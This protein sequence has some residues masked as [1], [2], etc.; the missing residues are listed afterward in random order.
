M[1]HDEK[2]VA[3]AENKQFNTVHF[4][5]LWTDVINNRDQRS[6]ESEPRT[7]KK[8]KKREKL[9]EAK[10]ANQPSLMQNR[11]NGTRNYRRSKGKAVKR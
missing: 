9:K 6:S 10:K 2:F 11:K 1:M 7:I 8:E 5:L 4:Y 3:I